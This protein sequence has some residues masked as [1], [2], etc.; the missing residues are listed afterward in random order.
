[1]I[2]AKLLL[3]DARRRVSR[4]EDDLRT[5]LDE[6]PAL[7]TPLRTE[8]EE[9]KE[10][11]RTGQH[12]P[13]W[14]DEQLTQIA[15]AWILALVFVRFIEDNGLVPEP[16]LANPD[17]DRA[18][19]A[20][21]RRM[22]HIRRNPTHGDREYLTHVIETF[23]GL[24]GCGVLFGDSHNP[25][26]RLGPSGIA[27]TELIDFFNDRDVASGKLTH[28][29]TDPEWD[30]RFLGDL[31]QDLSQSVRKKYALLQ[32]PDFVESFILDYTLEPALAV[33]GL[34]DFRMIDP[35][36]GSGHFL[37]G[38]FRRLLKRWQEI[39]DASV[40]RN[41]H[42]QRAL[43][44]VFGVDLNPYAVAIVRFRLL[45]DALR[46]CEVDT[47]KAAPD[48]Q[49][50]LAVGDSLLHG[51]HF[52]VYKGQQGWLFQEGDPYSHLYN[53]EDYSSLRKILDQRYHAV[54]GNPPYITVKDKG[55]NALY[56]NRYER[57]CHRQYSLGVPFTERFFDLSVVGGEGEEAGFV[58]LITANSFMKREF[59]K[60]LIEVFFKQVALTH[61]VDTSGAYIPGHG[62]PTVVLF[63]RN[64]LIKSDKARSDYRIRTVLGIRGEP[65]TPDDPKKGKV[66]CAIL[67]QIEDEGSESEFVSVI[68]QSMG[69]FLNHPWSLTGGGSVETM[70][71]IKTEKTL[72]FK[73]SDIGFSVISGEDNCLILGS[74]SAKRHG[75]NHKAIGFGAVVRD[76][77]IGGEESLIWPYE[78]GLAR[79]NDTSLQRI[80]RFLWPYKTNLRARKVFSQPIESRGLDW[81][82]IREVYSQRL[83]KPLIVFAFVAT[84][85]HF[86]FDR[87][88]KVFSRTAPVIKLPEG[89]SEEAHFELL[90]LLNSSTACFWM[91][92]VMSDKGNGGIGGGIG[93]EMW[94]RRFEHDGTKLKRL[95]VPER[96][97]ITLT[98]ELDGLAQR[99]GEVLP[100]GIRSRFPLTESE[101]EAFR[102]EAEI[103]RSR[104]V[105]LQE[106]LDWHYYYAFG[107]ISEPLL[108]TGDDLG[109]KPGERAFELILARDLAKGKIQTAWFARH[110]IEPREEIPASWPAEYRDVVSLRM[111][112]IAEN[113]SVALI[114]SPTYKRRWQTRDWDV[115]FREAAKEWLLEQLET[116]GLWSDGGLVTTNH[117]ARRVEREA[118]FR[119]VAE[120]YRGHTDIDL[121]KLVR[122]LVLDQSVPLL[123]NARFKP[124]GLRKHETWKETWELQRREDLGETVGE[125]PVPDK[126]TSADYQ[127]PRYYQ[128]RGKLDV[129]KERF[130]LFPGCA[131]D[132]DSSPVIVWAGWD[133]LQLAKAIATYY[134]EVKD[135]DA[136]SAERLAPLLACLRTL[137]FWLDLWH[138][139]VDPAVGMGMG[140]YFRGF[141]EEELFALGLD[142][143]VVDAWQ[144]PKRTRGRKR[145]TT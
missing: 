23:A 17:P 97:E 63:G 4:L 139:E 122:E 132:E 137:Q 86:V 75:L 16:Y 25:L 32:T 84:H 22:N 5:R 130:V 45:V 103:L 128:Q 131:R 24:P 69:K 136:W 94:E 64:L 26:W 61:V 105:F 14:R 9:A 55:L 20:R 102:E 27:A 112:C 33:F 66:W 91:K 110:G 116:E 29:F 121:D 111:A 119:K 93:D 118:G 31:Y 34:E 74:L 126:Y 65:S 62:T 113:K 56:R 125:I 15:V 82:S 120:Q 124:S 70:S 50:N 129:P 47:L 51:R 76:W 40:D 78:A 144:P 143:A 123:P 12:Y 46:F 59:G 89:A 35:A 11:G 3:R 92:Q 21:D 19:L 77:F 133:H 28:D 72:V 53:C 57:S 80:V 134:Q 36:C 114:E 108:F 54:V 88:G 107:L 100:S 42:I 127:K 81:W 96:L 101:I 71:L 85:N 8:H 41:T 106:E 39:S 48:F 60:K 73:A 109:I 115:L 138:N 30:T 104:M 135:Q 117:L 58:G 38:G 10:A 140:D 68:D 142:A 13:Q 43:D 95:P 90:G 2:D 87:G 141:V 98:T 79:V 18:E 7:E 37:L 1:M 67:E 49:I 99:M 44:G 52:N 83:E 6:D 145:S